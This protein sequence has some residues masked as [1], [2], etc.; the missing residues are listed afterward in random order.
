VFNFPVSDEVSSGTRRS[1]TSLKIASMRDR[2][3][4]GETEGIESNRRRCRFEFERSRTKVARERRW[5][6]NIEFV[7]PD[8]SIAVAIQQ[9][10]VIWKVGRVKE[11]GKNARKRET[12]MK[13]EKSLQDLIWLFLAHLLDVKAIHRDRSTNLAIAQI[14]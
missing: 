8:F 1:R 6:G 4:S 3:D 10:L 7:P 11:F 2:G 13:W 14:D 5:K 12:Y 9:S